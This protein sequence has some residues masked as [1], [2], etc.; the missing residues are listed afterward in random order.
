MRAL[1]WIKSLGLS[2]LDAIAGRRIDQCAVAFQIDGLRIV[3][4]PLG[5]VRS[6][7]DGRDALARSLEILGIFEVTRDRLCAG[8]HQCP[9]VRTWPDEDAELPVV[10]EEPSG[11]HAPEHPGCTYY[12]KHETTPFTASDPDARCFS[13]VR[14]A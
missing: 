5:R 14:G 4:A 12:E 8:F 9:I 7:D 2:V 10:F 6:R 1:A 11:N 3:V 13:T